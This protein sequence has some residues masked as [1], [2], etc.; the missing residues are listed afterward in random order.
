MTALTNSIRVQPPCLQQRDQLS[1]AHLLKPAIGNLRSTINMLKLLLLFALI[2]YTLAAPP[3]V[4]IGSVQHQHQHQ[5]QHQPQE[6]QVVQSPV[7]ILESGHEKNEDGSYSFHFRGEDGSFREESAV[8]RNQGQKD[9][10]LEVNGSYSYF[11]ANG[12]EVVVHYKADDHGF[13]PEGGNIPDE[14]AVAAKRVSELGP[15]QPPMTHNT[16]KTDNV[17]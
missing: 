13:V 10:H 6:Q 16:L 2:A 7:L 11:D 9:Q 8:V 5:Q 14:I 1:F 15:E 12:K 17:A 3:K 4:I